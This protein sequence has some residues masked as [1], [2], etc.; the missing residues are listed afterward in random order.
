MLGDKKKAISNYAKSLELN[1]NNEH[2][3]TKISS[4][5]KG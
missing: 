5:E 3:R 4:L 1:P 2:A